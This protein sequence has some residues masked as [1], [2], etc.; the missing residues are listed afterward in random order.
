[1]KL[2]LAFVLILGIVAI[3]C[4][5]GGGTTS[6]SST[7]YNRAPG[8][9]SFVSAQEGDYGSY[10]ADNTSAGDGAGGGAPSASDNGD[11]TGATPP[12]DSYQRSE[13]T[14]ANTEKAVEPD[15]YS[16]SG[17]LL[18][19]VNAYRGFFVVDVSGDPVV[20]GHLSFKGT[21]REMYVDGFTVYIL[22]DSFLTSSEGGMP[23]TSAALIKIDVTDPTAPTISAIKTLEGYISASRL[24]GNIIYIALGMNVYWGPLMGAAMVPEP[25]ST[26]LKLTSINGSTMATVETHSLDGWFSAVQAEDGRMALASTGN[27]GN[28]I[29]YLYDITD[30]DGHFTS[31]GTVNL[32]G[33]V[34]DKFKLHFEGSYC[35]AISRSF[36]DQSVSLFYSISLTGTAAIVHTLPIQYGEQPYA[37][38]FGDGVCYL[39]TFEQIDPLWVI[40]T[41]DPANPT[42]AGDVEV[43][44]WSI[45]IE[46]DGTNLIAV[47]YNSETRSVEV[48]L[49]DVSNPA[50]PDLT[51]RVTLGSSYEWTPIEAD[52]KAFTFLKDSGL[53]VIPVDG[54]EDP[55]TGNW[56]YISR[57]WLVDYSGSSLTKRGWVAT[58]GSFRRCIPHGTDLLVLS[59][60]GLF[61]VDI[62]DRSD[63]I[64]DF[65]LE[66]ASNVLAVKPVSGGFWRVAK[67][68]FNLRFEVVSGTDPNATASGLLVFN[69][70]ELFDFFTNGNTAY[71]MMYVASNSGAEYTYSSTLMLYVITVSGN[72]PVQTG[73]L[74]ITADFSRNW[75]S[76]MP[77]CM[78]YMYGIGSA[79]Q[80]RPDLIALKT[81]NYGGGVQPMMNVGGS[82]PGGSGDGGTGVGTPF[83]A[84]NSLLLIDLSNAASPQ[85]SSRIGL[86]WGASE[87]YAR[88]GIIYVSYWNDYG[89]DEQLNPTCK[90]FVVKVDTSDREDP[91]VS[92][93]INIPGRLIGLRG[94]TLF[95]LEAVYGTD[96]SFKRLL[97]SARIS[98]SQVLL[99]DSIAIPDTLWSLNIGSEG[100]KAAGFTRPAYYYWYDRVGM[101][102]GGVAADGSILPPG[103]QVDQESKLYVYDISDESNMS[104]FNSYTFASDWADVVYISEPYI[105]LL[106][107][108]NVMPVFEITA[109]SLNLLDYTYCDYYTD[110]IEVLSGDAYIAAG[111][112][113]VITLNLE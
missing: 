91:T 80:V 29:L 18:F 14:N 9:N 2:A 72:T 75:Y 82:E 38:R 61:R 6:T 22:M 12:T 110:H 103:D 30:V 81:E 104:L 50:A 49:F 63:P 57:A 17:D 21:G 43:P 45:Y 24:V 77:Y 83:E 62:S 58:G 47:G 36:A 85:I 93:P 107:D 4:G 48:S 99:L 44:G 78:P 97:N 98:G 53:L 37:S 105:F 66:L 113:G 51:S 20:I 79:I 34:N 23:Q 64:V 8:M 92:S 28:T 96:Y 46:A 16:L 90:Y 33:T 102:N 69:R 95:C 101:E 86:P 5:G 1:K 31:L 89:Y 19:L 112:F 40:D 76:D 94:S 39:V 65:A 32:S 15:L 73:E 67:D 11:L 106:T 26:G 111:Y 56:N 109:T 71:L 41:S 55:G 13:S 35:F 100:T 74:E 60:T 3:S 42:I 87:P 7:T 68:D 59:T 84:T 88:D 52:D 54:Y 27:D 70:S 25:V 10:L 108:W